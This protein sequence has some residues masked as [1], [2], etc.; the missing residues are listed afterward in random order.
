MRFQAE[1]CALLGFDGLE[2]EEL[3]IVLLVTPSALQGFYGKSRAQG[4]D[5]F[6]ITGARPGSRT[7][8]TRAE[9]EGRSSV[10]RPRSAVLRA[11]WFFLWRVSL[12]SPKPYDTPGPYGRIIDETP[13]PEDGTALS[14]IARS[15]LGNR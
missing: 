1:A 12:P 14:I 10:G 3:E 8:F 6:T 11:F 2:W 5:S 7:K 9:R 15:P 13:S 4:S